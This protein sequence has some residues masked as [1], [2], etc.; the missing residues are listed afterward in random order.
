MTVDIDDGL[1]ESLRSFLRKIVPNATLEDAVTH[2]TTEAFRQASWAPAS[3]I[4]SCGQSD[5]STPSC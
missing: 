2:Y 1:R 5:S 4:R 3:S